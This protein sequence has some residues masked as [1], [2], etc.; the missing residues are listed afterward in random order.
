MADP[1]TPS[2]SGVRSFLREN[3]LY[4]VVPLAIVFV[5]LL[6]LIL[7]GDDSPSKFIYNLW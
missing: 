7:F 6:A 4:I 1:T 3:W 2:S 5:L